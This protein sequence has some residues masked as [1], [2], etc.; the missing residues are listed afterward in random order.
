MMHKTKY[1]NYFIDHSNDSAVDSIIGDT[2]N[3]VKDVVNFG[4]SVVERFKL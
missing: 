3:K 1:E 4:S 2:L